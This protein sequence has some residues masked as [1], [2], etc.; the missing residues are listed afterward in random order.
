MI[1]MCALIAVAGFV[2]CVFC[3]VSRAELVA[4]GDAQYNQRADRDTSNDTSVKFVDGHD[5]VAT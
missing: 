2:F 5:T 3:R 4:M 1:G